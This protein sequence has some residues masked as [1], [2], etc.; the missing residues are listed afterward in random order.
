ML[1]H[2]KIH[3]NG[4]R[5][6]MCH[7]K[8]THEKECNIWHPLRRMQLSLNV[9]VIGR[10]NW[11]RK[12]SLP[13][14]EI[15]LSHIYPLDIL[16]ARALKF[17][18]F[19]VFFSYSSPTTKKILFCEGMRSSQTIYCLLFFWY[20]KMYFYLRCNKNKLSLYVDAGSRCLSL[21]WSGFLL[22]CK[23]IS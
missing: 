19:L 9:L 17:G 1:K 21:F 7:A 15:F 4:W 20:M 13:L 12:N 14:N 22:R 23:V 5:E 6:K 10:R 3:E 2:T 16:R 11:E 18:D 8:K